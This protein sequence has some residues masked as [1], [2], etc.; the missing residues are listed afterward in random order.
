M[1]WPSQEGF[2]KHV[3]LSARIIWNAENYHP[4]SANSRRAISQ[5]L[6]KAEDYYDLPEEEMRLRRSSQ[7][8]DADRLQGIL[9]EW[10]GL[11]IQDIH[12]KENR[13][14]G[15]PVRLHFT[16]CSSD[17]RIIGEFVTAPK[18]EPYPPYD[19][20]FKGV[21][22]HGRFLALD[23]KQISN[24]SAIHFGSILLEI[25]SNGRRLEGRFLGYGPH[26]DR[27][28]FGTLDVKKGR[29]ESEWVDRIEFK[30][31]TSLQSA[32]YELR[33]D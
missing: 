23:Y 14:M 15:Y 13:P 27:L 11:M 29:L 20:S 17:N 30:D 8:E 9:G 24:R 31:N 1:E 28:V 32:R 21:Y 4:I 22:K 3:G 25:P 16:D 33:S 10:Y 6:G 19:N 7:R 2:G 5:G 12:P 18:G 26:S